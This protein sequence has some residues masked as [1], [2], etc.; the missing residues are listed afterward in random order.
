MAL[1]TKCDMP[2]LADLNQQ[3]AVSRYLMTGLIGSDNNLNKNFVLNRKVFV[4]LADKAVYEYL[5]ARD[6]V[7]NQI[8]D[9]EGGIYLVG[10]INHL[11]N[12][13]ISLRGLF[14]IFDHIKKDKD[15]KFFIE[16][17]SR[18]L[19]ESKFG[20]I[21]NIRDAIIHIEEEIRNG[22]IKDGQMIALDISEDASMIAIG[23]RELSIFDLAN[24]IRRF[25]ALA[26]EIA[27]YNA[28]GTKPEDFKILKEKL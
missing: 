10:I 7:I 19:I 1:P 17:T 22:K 5:S 26:L 3:K 6:N 16:R 21:K 4:R 23:D 28:P 13:I 18:K 12:C 11:E 15:N 27:T 14:Y 2:D 8:S 9:K 25:H 24:N 20:V